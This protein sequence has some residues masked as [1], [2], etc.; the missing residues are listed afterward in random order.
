MVAHCF[1]ARTKPL[2]SSYNRLGAVCDA[3]TLETAYKG[4]RIWR[5]VNKGSPDIEM[6]EQDSVPDLVL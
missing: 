3:G 5:D 6:M 2:T 4:R 1:M